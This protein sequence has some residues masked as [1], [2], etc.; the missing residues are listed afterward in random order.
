M[1]LFNFIKSQ[2]TIL[3][4]VQEYTTLKKN[5][6]YWK[7]CCPFHHEKTPSFSVSP[8]KEIFYCFGCHMGGDAISFIEKIEQCSPLEAAH[9][10]A[11]RFNIAIPENIAHEPESA[12]TQQE[13]DSYFALCQ[14]VAAWC[15]KNLQHNAELTNYV[16]ERGFS[17][18]M[19]NHF[20]LGYF[21]GGPSA[22]KSFLAHM[23]THNI[24]TQDLIDANI[25]APSKSNSFYSPFEERLMFPIKDHL[26][27]WCGFG[28]R[29]IKPHDD[30]AKY[31]NSK[32]NEFFT[33]G[34]LLFGFDLAKKSM[35]ETGTVFLVEG[36]TDCM[37]MV[38]HG[39]PNTV[40]T[41]GT[42]CTSNHLKTLSRYVQQVYLVYD[43][44]KAGQQAVMRIA[45]LCWQVDLEL[46]VISLPEGQDPASWLKNN[47]TLKPQAQEAKDLFV[48][49]IDSIGKNFSGKLIPEKVRLTRS[50]VDIIRTIDDPLKQ[51]FLLQ[52]AAKTFDIPFQA[53]KQELGRSTH[54]PASQAASPVAQTQSPKAAQAQISHALA[55][56]T[57]LSRKPSSQSEHSSAQSNRAQDIQNPEAP[58][59]Q[60]LGAPDR[61]IETEMG[62]ASHEHRA[63]KTEDSQAQA[64]A[65]LLEKQIF[66]AIINNMQLLNSSDYLRSVKYSL[67]Y[68]PQHL[69]AVLEKLH[70]TYTRDPNIA[71]TSFFNT[72]D[73]HEKQW[74]SQM[75]LE[76]A[77]YIATAD[78]EQLIHQLHKTHWKK[79]VF[80]IKQQIARANRA[81]NSAQ[82]EKILQDFLYLKQKM[83]PHTSHLSP[84]APDNSPH[85]STE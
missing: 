9:Y 66:C 28:G 19:V 62:Q 77:E 47:K 79:I 67:N 23:R 52:K 76:S 85:K 46:F 71:F 84:A 56:S 53:L 15:H 30:R 7:G 29:I 82:V 33:K 44:D 34:S 8:H 37:A 3:D 24:L 31:Y 1:S 35:Q 10:L 43:N 61:A 48:F 11:Q 51:D 36:Y 78:F 60:H 32:E 2:V 20:C 72:L 83:M 65:S 64:P 22:L 39:Y 59:A 27:R 38:Q 16:T 80:D 6:A 17:Q 70:E 55:A 12:K 50:V 58:P 69:L 68:L 45:Q 54:T 41:L 4:V 73:N 63:E 14:Q 40:A 75:V 81:G 49:F 26:G 42:A 21:P 18:E 5:G 57:P 13:R 74:V 25:I